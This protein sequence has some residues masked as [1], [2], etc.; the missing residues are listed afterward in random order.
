MEQQKVALCD[1][2]LHYGSRLADY[3]ERHV[4]FPYTVLYFSDVAQLC[5]YAGGQE[6]T[7]LILS[8]DLLADYSNDTG[9]RA[10]NLFVLTKQIPVPKDAKTEETWKEGTIYVY[11][12]QSA[13]NV[14]RQ[15]L[16]YLCRINEE[17]R[18]ATVQG[19]AGTK[20]IGIY[21][22][23][24]RCMQTSFSLL[25]G[26]ILTKKKRTLYLNTEA[27]SGFRGLFSRELKPDITDLMYYAKRGRPHLLE[28]LERMID[29]IGELE[30]IPPAAAYTDLHVIES[31]QWLKFFRELR[32]DGRFGYIILD[33]TEH[34]DGLFRILEQCDLVYTIEGEDTVSAAKLWEYEQMLEVSQCQ[35]I[36]GKTRKKRLPKIRHMEI[37]F[38]QLLYSELADYVRVL[39]QED[40]SS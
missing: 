37:S 21:S 40:F 30:Y 7:Y 16:G 28:K 22:P 29:T 10:K 38:D 32:G 18:E 14:M 17:E 2:N 31:S 19:A 1:S 20:L 3:L 5:A 26:Q 6:L 36:L 8:E 35:Q 24:K 4:G 12:Y 13:G 9:V 27:F 15:I 25:L 34:V 39:V 23:V 33:L 11:R